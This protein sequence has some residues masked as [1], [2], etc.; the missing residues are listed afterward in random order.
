MTVNTQ[1]IVYHSYAYLLSRHNINIFNVSSVPINEEEKQIVQVVQYLIQ[2]FYV[3]FD[4][5]IRQDI[6]IVK[7][8]FNNLSDCLTSLFLHSF[9]YGIDWSHIIGY[10]V[11]L[12]E[13]TICYQQKNLAENA[14]EFALLNMWTHFER[15]LNT[16]IQEQGGWFSLAKMTV[17]AMTFIN[18]IN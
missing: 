13:V 14:L 9:P 4:Q 7:N 2:A 16:W 15:Y 10:M 6:D 11:Y 1:V 8:A 18:L 3:K 5:R 12:V 17:N